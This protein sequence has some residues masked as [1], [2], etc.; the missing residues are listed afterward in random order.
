M[1]LGVTTVHRLGRLR[2]LI[3]KADRP[4]FEAH[5][6]LSALIAENTVVERN[7]EYVSFDG[8]WSSSLTDS[9]A[10]VSLI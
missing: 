5:N 4:Y 10:R 2:Q 3:D 8:V 7:G 9:T 1:K 6:P